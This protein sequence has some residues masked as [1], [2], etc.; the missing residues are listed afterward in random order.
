VMGAGVN[1]HLWNV[2]F[3][4]EIYLKVNDHINIV[5]V[6]VTVCEL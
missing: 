1:S 3:T 4:S 5:P 6:T 2:N